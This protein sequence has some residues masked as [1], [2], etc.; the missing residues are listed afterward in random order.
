MTPNMNIALSSTSKASLSVRSLHW[1]IALLIISAWAFIYSKGLFDKGSAP[2]SAME[3]AHMF[4]GLLIFVLMPLRLAARWLSPL[5]EITPAPPPWQMKL[6]KILHVLLYISMI[7]LP[8]LGVFFVQAG[9]NTV[10]PFGLFTLPTLIDTDKTLSRSVKEVHE[11]LGLVLIYL[12]I[13]HAGAALFH[14]FIQRDNT[15]KRMM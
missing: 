1:I 5:P 12:V 8:I 14:H 4:V 9:G 11:T 7:A 13:A 15:L 6:A 10:S 2:R 3:Q